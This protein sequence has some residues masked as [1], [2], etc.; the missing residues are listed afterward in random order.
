MVYKPDLHKIQIVLIHFLLDIQLSHRKK[1]IYLYSLDRLHP[2]CWH[3]QRGRMVLLDS[4]KTRE[5][6]SGDEK[7]RL[8]LQ[9]CKMVTFS[10][11]YFGHNI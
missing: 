3:L 8:M 10:C 11:K 4:M 6:I 7:Q 1:C 9:N 2:L 5:L